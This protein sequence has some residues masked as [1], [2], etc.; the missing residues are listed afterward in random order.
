MPTYLQ[1]SANA[2]VEID[3]A[4]TSQK[5]VRLRYRIKDTTGW[6]TPPK[7]ENTSGS[8]AIFA[9]MS[10]RAETTYEVQAWLTT[11]DSP[12]PGT[13]IYEFTTLA[14]DPGISNLKFENIE[15]TSATA[16]VK[17]ANAGTEMK[18]VFLKHSMDGT[19]EWAQLPF[20]TITYTDSTSVDR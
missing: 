3:Y 2:T 13:R 20:P 9:L 4:G 1:T 8:S 15:Q 11:S 19:D 6:S 10:L 7:T 18:E 12:P 17:I 5:T 16:M 14:D